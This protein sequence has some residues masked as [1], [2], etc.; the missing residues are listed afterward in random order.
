MNVRLEHTPD[1][2]HD[3]VEIFNFLSCLPLIKLYQ[4][5]YSKV[6]INGIEWLYID[7]QYKDNKYYIIPVFINLVK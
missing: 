5:L 6:Y 2:F 4:F 3:V 1:I 7:I